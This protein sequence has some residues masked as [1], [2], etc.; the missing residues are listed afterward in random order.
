MWYLILGQKQKLCA[1]YKIESQYK[2]VYELLLNDFT[3]PK[4]KTIAERNAMALM[5]KQN[6]LTA[7]GFFILSQNVASAIQVTL[8]RLNDPIL[9]VLIYRL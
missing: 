4:Y 3:I 7:I 9:A 8:T 5:S 1:L 2:K 6:Y